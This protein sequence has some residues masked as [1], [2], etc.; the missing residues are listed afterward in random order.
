MRLLGAWPFR[1]EGNMVP[2]APEYIIANMAVGGR[3]PVPPDSTTPFP[4]YMDIKSIR[5]YQY[6]DLKDAPVTKPW[7]AMDATRVTPGVVKPGQS[8]EIQSS[9]ATGRAYPSVLTRVYVTDFYGKKYLT[10]I[11]VPCQDVKPGSPNMVKARWTVPANLPPGLYTIA[12][13]FSS[14]NPKLDSFLGCA[15]RF[16]V[17]STGLTNYK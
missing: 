9:F 8:I 4:A 3:W 13:K 2:S 15:T 14:D 17:S 6:R 7:L 11:D 12:L 16:E 10:E 1:I 5:V